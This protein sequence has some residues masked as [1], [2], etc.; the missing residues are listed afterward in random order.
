MAEQNSKYCDFELRIWKFEMMEQLKKWL[1]L[2][3]IRYSDVFEVTN[4]ASDLKIHK[5]KMADG[6]QKVISFEFE[7]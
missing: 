4:Y 7:F 5:F 6:T 2:E 1:H 3:K